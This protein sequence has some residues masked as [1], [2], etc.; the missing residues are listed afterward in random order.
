MST[1]QSSPGTTWSLQGL[2]DVLADIARRRA[3]ASP[4]QKSN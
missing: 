3:A 1:S 2:C 4:Q